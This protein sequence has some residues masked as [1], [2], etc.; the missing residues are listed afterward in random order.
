MNFELKK[1]DWARFLDN[2]GKRRF[3]WMTEVQVIGANVGDQ[4]L[5]NGLPLN[6]ITVETVG[7]RTCIDI[8]VGETTG[9]HQTHSIVNPTRVAFLAG[10]DSH[11]DVVDIEEAD[12]TK[13]LIR[14][15]EPMGLLVGFAAYEVEVATA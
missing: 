8:S 6:G 11:G 7:A 13:T 14:L 2:L 3:E 10:D 9:H 12:G 15:I 4:T 5:S 1:E